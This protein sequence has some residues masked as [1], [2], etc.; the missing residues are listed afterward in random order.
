MSTRSVAQ[1]ENARIGMTARGAAAGS[2]A[3]LL[4][5]APAAGLGAAAAAGGK[6]HGYATRRGLGDITNRAPAAEIAAQK[7]SLVMIIACPSPAACIVPP[8]PPG[9]P[10]ARLG[11]PWSGVLQR[12]GGLCVRDLT[13][14]RLPRRVFAA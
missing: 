4:S 5:V 8:F 12:A 14:P 1:D 10:L 7:V 9:P 11:L 6:T 13:R 3:A 2:S